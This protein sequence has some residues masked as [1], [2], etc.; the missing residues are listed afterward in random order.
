MKKVIDGKLYNTE[1]AEKV[2]SWA[3]NYNRGDFNRVDQDLYLTK[4]GNYF[5]H[6]K[7]PVGY[8]GAVFKIVP[9]DDVIEAFEWASQKLSGDEVEELFPKQIE[10]A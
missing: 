8:N 7:G 3:N 10:E 4:K 1:T 6:Q 5:M 9:F 2:A